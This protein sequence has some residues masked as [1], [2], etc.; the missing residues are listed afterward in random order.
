MVAGAIADMVGRALTWTSLRNI[1]K[2]FSI[3]KRL[4][5]FCRRKDP[6]PMCVEEDLSERVGY[7]G[8]KKSSC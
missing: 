6:E 3:V 4:R 2:N 5:R 7:W 1:V 8:E